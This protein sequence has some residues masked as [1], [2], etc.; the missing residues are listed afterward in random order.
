MRTYHINPATTTELA[1]ARAMGLEAKW[2]VEGDQVI[3]Y[4]D[5]N[6]LSNLGLPNAVD[7]WLHQRASDLL[8]LV[9]WVH[10]KRMNGNSAATFFVTNGLSVL[11]RPTLVFPVGRKSHRPV[12][13]KGLWSASSNDVANECWAG[14]G[15]SLCEQRKG[16]EAQAELGASGQTIN[17]LSK[18]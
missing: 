6:A 7:I 16:E 5:R 13:H 3:M 18:G 15:F 4:N 1:L 17:E 2:L 10:S 12:C 8:A 11:N 14:F 9:R